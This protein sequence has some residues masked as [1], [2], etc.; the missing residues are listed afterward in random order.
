MVIVPPL[1][2]VSVDQMSLYYFRL[3]LRSY[4]FDLRVSAGLGLA[5]PTR[6]SVHPARV[7]AESL[8]RI[9]ELSAFFSAIDAVDPRWH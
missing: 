7:R 4:S 6:H 1:G 3:Y 8:L 9:Q 5:S 2:N